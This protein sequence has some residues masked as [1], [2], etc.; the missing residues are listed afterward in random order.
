MVQN[1]LKFFKMCA[2]IVLISYLVCKNV[3]NFFTNIEIDSSFLSSYDKNF[4][5]IFT[6]CKIGLIFE[7]KNYK[8]LN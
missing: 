8:L 3:V 7:K 4:L 6:N 1:Y 5:K 2:K